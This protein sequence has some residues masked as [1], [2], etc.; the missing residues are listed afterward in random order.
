MALAGDHTIFTAIR[1]NT[2]YPTSLCCPCP[3]SLWKLRPDTRQDE[4]G[5]FAP[6]VT[7]HQD[8]NSHIG[9][10]G[11]S[12]T[13]I[14]PQ[15]AQDAWLSTAL[16]ELAQM[17]GAFSR[18]TPGAQPSTSTAEA[19]LS[20]GMHVGD[21]LDLCDALSAV[22]PAVSGAGCDVPSPDVSSTA[23][24]PVAFQQGKLQP[25]QLRADIFGALPPTFDV[26]KTSNLADHLGEGH[27]V[28]STRLLGR[29]RHYLSKPFAAQR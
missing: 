16:E 15:V 10:G 18:A 26:I 28:S 1:L 7:K 11:S 14:A 2:P 25:L 4:Y 9:E 24:P 22:S 27:L 23:I 3:V 19:R 20:I 17:C 29:E 8:I 6:R 13:P 5:K 12:A 21:A